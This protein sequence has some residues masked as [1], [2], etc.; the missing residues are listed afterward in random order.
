MATKLINKLGI[1]VIVDDAQAAKLEALG[2]K[3]AEQ[4]K[5]PRKRTAKTKE[6]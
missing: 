5:A 3:K 2:Y 4:P 1:A 6:Q